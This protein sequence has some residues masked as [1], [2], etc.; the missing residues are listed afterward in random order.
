MSLEATPIGK[1]RFKLKRLQA[2]MLKLRA[3]ESGKKGK[4]KKAAP[5]KAVK[6]KEKGKKAVQEPASSVATEV[7]SSY[8]GAYKTDDVTGQYSLDL[9]VPSGCQVCWL[10]ENCLLAPTFVEL[11]ASSTLL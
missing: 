2:A 8:A 4:E 3:K 1:A 6:D 9:S 7:I 11:L 5:E 10:A